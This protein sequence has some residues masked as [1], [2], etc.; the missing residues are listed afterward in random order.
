M[1]TT[2][3]ALRAIKQC[4]P[5]N[6][7]LSEVGERGRLRSLRALFLAGEWSEPTLVSMYQ[8]LMDK[9]GGNNSA[10]VVDNWWSAEAGSPITSR[11]IAPQIGL[12]RE[13][14]T[15]KAIPPIK[16]GSAGKPMPGFDIRVVD[17][18]GEEVPAGSMGNIVLGLPLGPTAFN[19][20]WLDEERFY[21]SYLKRF[22]SRFLGTGD[23]GWIDHEGYIHVMSRNDD[24]LNISAYRMSSGAIEEAIASH[25]QVVETCVVAIPDDLKGQR[26]FAFISLSAPD[27]PDSAIPAAT[28][29]Q[30]VQSL[31]RSRVGAFASLGE[32]GV[33]G[34]L[35]RDVDVPSTAEDAMAV[36]VARA[37]VQ[38]YFHKNKGKH[39]AIEARE[40]A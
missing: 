20:L 8:E 2:P 38:E 40:K 11:A 3:T 13:I 27:H 19:T 10:H 23:A 28:V 5:S 16:P 30:E 36:Q 24:V 6:A 9:Y 26:P 29:A 14:A 37:K 32:N 25:P 34:D 39:K 7:K 12:R 35:D 17:D 33:Y 15:S 1:S 22:E 18:G 21:E 4:D 31:V